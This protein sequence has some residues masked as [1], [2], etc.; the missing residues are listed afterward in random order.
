MLMKN[1]FLTFVLAVLVVLTGLTL[2]HSV[3]SASQPSSSA[4][5]NMVAIGGTPM[6]PLP[7]AIGGT[8]MPPLPQAIGGTP[9]P[10][11][12]Q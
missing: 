12:P 10:P 2:R 1:Y 9:M 6:P 5:N 8:P 11:L 7:Q 3:A 4:Q